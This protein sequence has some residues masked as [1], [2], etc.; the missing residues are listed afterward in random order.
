MLHSE[1]LLLQAARLRALVVIGRARFRAR[2]PV[3][4]KHLFNLETSTVQSTKT[5]VEPEPDDQARV[6]AAELLERV[7][8]DANGAMFNDDDPATW[9]DADA[10]APEIVSLGPVRFRIVDADS[11]DLAVAAGAIEPG[12]PVLCMR[13]EFDATEGAATPAIGQVVVVPTEEAGVKLTFGIWATHT[14]LHAPEA[15]DF[16]ADA[17]RDPVLDSLAPNQALLVQVLDA[18]DA[19]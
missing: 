16:G 4:S 17:V 13:V 5:Y 3:T 8:L 11:V 14:D 6:L 15:P 18:E 12:V 1:T 19:P 10:A 7:A 2:V 9:A